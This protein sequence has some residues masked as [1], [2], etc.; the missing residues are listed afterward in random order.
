M[1]DVTERWHVETRFLQRDRFM[2]RSAVISSER[3]PLSVEQSYTLVK[4]DGRWKITDARVYQ[5]W[6]L[7]MDVEGNVPSAPPPPLPTGYGRR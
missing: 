3:H 6:V 1:V 4:E 7:G 2:P 5:P